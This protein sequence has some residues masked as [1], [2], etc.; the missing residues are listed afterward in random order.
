MTVRML[1]HF[2]DIGVEEISVIQEEE[3]IEKRI[4]LNEM[5]LTEAV[6]VMK[7]SGAKRVLDLGCGEGKLLRKLMAEKQLEELVGMDVSHQ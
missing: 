5:R 3:K 6:E 2:D 4:G 7:Q 1:L